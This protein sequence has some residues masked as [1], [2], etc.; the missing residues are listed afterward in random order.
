MFNCHT[1]MF[2]KTIFGNMFWADCVAKLR[3][4]RDLLE[5]MPGFYK[6]VPYMRTLENGITMLIMWNTWNAKKCKVAQ[7]V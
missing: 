2:I 5:N 7:Y 3:K 4:I 1:H 6:F